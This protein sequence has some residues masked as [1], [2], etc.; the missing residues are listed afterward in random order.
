MPSLA[1]NSG[2]LLLFHG[3]NRRFCLRYCPPAV[4]AILDISAKLSTM[5]PKQT[6]DPKN[7]KTIPAVP[8]FVRPAA[9]ALRMTS[10]VPMAIATKPKI[11]VK[12]KFLLSSC[13]FPSRRI[14]A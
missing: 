3:M 8:P 2:Q 9:V 1:Q 10:H 13:F 12:R 7:M 11:E 5:V 6:Y 14:S 4:G